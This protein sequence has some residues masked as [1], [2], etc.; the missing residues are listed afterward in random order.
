SVG[1]PITLRQLLHHTSGLRDYFTLLA[2]SGWPT[3]GQLTE[4]Q[5]L[6]LVARQKSLNFQ[7]GDEFLYS[8]TG[9]ALLAVVR[10]PTSAQSR[11]DLADARIF[12]PLGM[13]H[14]TFRDDHTTLVP[15]RAL[16]YQPSPAG[17]HLSQPQFDVVGDGG[18]Y[19]SVEDLAKWAAN[20]T[21]G[22][23]GGK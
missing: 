20:F 13:T 6:A 9:Y 3:D 11:R 15:Q 23:V 4:A 14:T 18:A 16:G 1:A 17:Y 19:S 10:K 12:K 22:R 7:P 2:V 21:T 8:N 5:F